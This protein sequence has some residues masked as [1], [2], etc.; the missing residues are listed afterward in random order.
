V[1][2]IHRLY[3]VN[4]MNLNKYKTKK[5]ISK[6]AYDSNVSIFRTLVIPMLYSKS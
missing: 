4:K 1:E 3:S 2:V 6:N 5:T